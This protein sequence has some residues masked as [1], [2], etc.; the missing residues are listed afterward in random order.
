MNL[1]VIISV[2]LVTSMC[3]C[4]IGPDY[5]RPAVATPAAYKEQNGW[6]PAAVAAMPGGGAWWRIY[7]DQVLDDL[8]VQVEVNNQNLKA[9]EAAYRQ[10]QALVDQARASYFPN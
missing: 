9:A 4:A 6:K 1:R 10:A 7:D 5:K 8:E 2:L 3:S